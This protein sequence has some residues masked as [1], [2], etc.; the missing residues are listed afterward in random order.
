MN[1]VIEISSL[2]KQYKNFLL[3]DISFSVPCGFVCGFIGENGVGK[4]TTL[5][6]ILGMARKDSGNIQLFGK[7]ADD[8]T[9]K[10]ERFIR[11]AL[12]SGRLD[13]CGYRKSYAPFL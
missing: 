7:P 9:W 3:D 4:T 11:T 12:L 6:L 10:E 13:T 2:K 5:K 8:V 1:H